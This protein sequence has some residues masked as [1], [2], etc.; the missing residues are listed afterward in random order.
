MAISW[1]RAGLFTVLLY[2]V[3]IVISSLTMVRE[4]YCVHSVNFCLK[5]LFWDAKSEDLLYL[6][7]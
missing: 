7:I 2:V 3:L 4:V 6:G 5:T 1:E